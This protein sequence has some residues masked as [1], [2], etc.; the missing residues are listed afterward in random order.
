MKTRCP[1]FANLATFIVA[2]VLAGCDL[3]TNLNPH[4]QADRIPASNPTAN[5]EFHT[6]GNG[7]VLWRC[8]K[9]TGETYYC[10]LTASNQWWT[11][12]PEAPP[13]KLYQP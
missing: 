8:N 5:Y 3:K 12:V 1:N 13:V 10:N 2:C 6:I 4:T 11:L 7:A 9:L